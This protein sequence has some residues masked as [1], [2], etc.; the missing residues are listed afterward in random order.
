MKRG[1]YLSLVGAIVLGFGAMYAQPRLGLTNANG[2]PT[3]ISQG[4]SYSLSGWIVNRGN[5]AFSGTVDMRIN[6]NGSFN[7]LMTNNFSIPSLP[8]GDSIYWYESSYNFPPGQLRLGNNDIL[9]WPTAPSGGTILEDSLYVTMYN[10]DGQAAF[11]LSDEGVEDMLDGVLTN[12][13]YTF[14]LGAVNVGLAASTDVVK[15]VA[16]IQGVGSRSLAACISPVQVGGT[17]TFNV[18]AFK[19]SELF[20]LTYMG[21]SEDLPALEFYVEMEQL[22]IDPIN[23]LSFPL[24]TPTG[25]T[26]GSE[27]PA[28]SLYPNPGNS[29]LHVRVTTGELLSVSI[30]DTGMR[31]V[32]TSTLDKIDISDLAAGVYAVKVT[33]NQGVAVQQYLRQ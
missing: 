3:V 10:S 2:M 21:G 28:V 29:F 33:T 12:E 13:Y 22:A 19:V 25:V 18:E 7:G 15:L 14:E 23:R 24:I 27:G 5:Q 32:M 30:F 20:D 11:R 8:V 9:V 17:A 4:G 6:I 1:R 16:E 26:T 31:E